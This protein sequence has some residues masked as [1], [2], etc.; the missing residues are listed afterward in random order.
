MKPMKKRCKSVK[1]YVP[2]TILSMGHYDINYLIE[3]TDEDITKCKVKD[4]KKLKTFEDISFL[5]NNQYLWSKIKI[6]TENKFINLLIFLNKISIE[7]N[8]SYIEFISYETPM[9]YNESVKTM[10]KTVNDFHFFFVNDFSI[11]PESK[12]YFNLKIKYRN[13]E[14]V[15][16]FDK[17]ENANDTNTNNNSGEK[18]EE[19]KNDN[20]N[21]NNDDGEK[22]KEIKVDIQSEENKNDKN[23]GFLKNTRNIFNKIKLDCACY[24]YFMCSIE[25]TLEITPYE[26][27]IE[28]IIY[29][30]L[31]LHSQFA[32]EFGDVSDY[33]NNEESMALLN[34]MYLLTDIFLF[35][36]KDTINNFK[37][38][39]ELLSKENNKNNKNKNKLDEN[40]SQKEPPDNKSSPLPVEENNKC[41]SPS[42]IVVKKKHKEKNMTEKDIFDYFKHTIA[43]NGALSILNNKLA[44]FIDNYFSK[45]T[46][47]EVPMNIKAT[48]LSYEIKPYPKL[49][50]TNVD[51]VEYF[52]GKLRQNKNFF[53]SIFYAGVLNRIFM[54]KRKNIGLEILY[55]AYL[56]GHEILKRMLNIMANEIDF[57]DDPKFYI[58]KINNNEVN[59]YVTKEYY[60]KKES[61]FV[62]DCTNYEKSKLKYY[63]PLLDY[64]LNE[65]FG[66]KLIRKELINKGFI[67]SKGFVNYD[68]VYMKEMGI[69]K[70]VTVKRNAKSVC[71]NEIVKNILNVNQKNRILSNMPS[72]R[73]KLP[74]INPKSKK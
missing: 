41:E 60:N 18:T 54:A 56:I 28:F 8:K 58:V 6:E 7:A 51:I 13:E 62:L 26:D 24:N 9:Y 10:F 30:K 19:V 73:I 67:N 20:D 59:D 17:I 3:L 35:D 27:F 53:K 42:Q 16:N 71:Q 25:D 39:Y 38:H 37:K 63:M 45:V 72:M 44:I 14:T 34:K 36:E 61:K 29:I 33:F 40:K 55:P 46:F 43:C 31:N 69:Q 65:F 64:N 74:A 47:I 1:T 12:K 32:I 48:T 21:N 23:A 11:N 52:K 22:E 2:S 50:H 70:K 49:S 57:P 4:I 68:P 5:I 66:N 15:I